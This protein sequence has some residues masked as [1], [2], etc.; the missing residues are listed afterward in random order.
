MR[1]NTPGALAISALLHAAVAGLVLFF[2][3]AATSVVQDNPKVFE[4]IAGAGDNYAATSAPAL[5]VTG[6][7]KGPAAPGPEP[8]PAP[9]KQA[10]PRIQA[11]PE[12]VPA[13]PQKPVDL[14]AQLKRVEE[15][16]ER[17]LEEK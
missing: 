3:Y 5:G 12:A 9:A 11:A 6:G 15:R 14:V 8:P 4:L 17:R 10:P 1:S 13:K 2:S 7:I 16:R